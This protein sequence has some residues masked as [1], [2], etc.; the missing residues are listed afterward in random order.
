MVSKLH[1]LWG[2]SL[3]HCLSSI[4]NYNDCGQG[5]LQFRERELVPL[6][7]SV[8]TP[9]GKNQVMSLI[10]FGNNQINQIHDS[11]Q[12]LNLSCRVYKIY[13]LPFKILFFLKQV[14]LQD[15]SL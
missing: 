7:Y 1:K 11:K 3:G 12:A 8:E 9:R 10:F 13:K 6:Q 5:Q 14:T 15:C 4:P 2:E